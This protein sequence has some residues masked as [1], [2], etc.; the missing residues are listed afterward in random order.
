MIRLLESIEA[1]RSIGRLR[2][3]NL[4][5]MIAA[6]MSVGGSLEHLI[7][8][9]EWERRD[10]PAS[11][12]AVKQS[13]VSRRRTRLAEYIQTNGQRPATRP[14]SWYAAFREAFPSDAASDKTLKAD[15]PH[16]LALLRKRI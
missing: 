15:Y 7:A 3:D 14:G 12:N 2:P 13:R 6:A 1:L 11:A 5:A 4:D 9:I 10:P 8:Q 16:A